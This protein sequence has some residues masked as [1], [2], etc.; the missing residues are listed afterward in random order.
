MIQIPQ[1]RDIE[2]TPLQGSISGIPLVQNLATVS[3]SW[4]P[5][6]LEYESKQILLQTRGMLTW[7]YATVSGGDYYTI[8]NGG[9]LQAP[10]VAASGTTIAWVACDTPTTFELMIG[11]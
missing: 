2:Q 7:Y 6:V 1:P 4:Y 3:G 11:S 5:I 9:E 8:K 10:I